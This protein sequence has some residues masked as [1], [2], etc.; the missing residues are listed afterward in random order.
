MPALPGTALNT[1]SLPASPTSLLSIVDL[2]VA[3]N[4]RGGPVDVRRSPDAERIGSTWLAAVIHLNREAFRRRAGRADHLRG[5]SE[6][7]VGVRPTG[8]GGYEKPINGLG[9]D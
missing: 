1:Y 4:Q 2:D 8:S 3:A 6:R 5:A 7:G 9:L